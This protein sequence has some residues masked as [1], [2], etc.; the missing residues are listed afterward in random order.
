MSFLGAALELASL[1][2]HVFP[3][4]PNTKLP[5]IEDFPN[6]ASQDPAQIKKWW[7]DPVME[8]E[9][10]Y[11]VGISTTRFGEKE[12]LLVV[13]VDNK[14]D[15][16]G[17]QELKRLESEG[18]S[19]PETFEQ[20]TPTGGRH[21]VFRVISPVKQGVSVLGNGLDVRS[22]GGYIVGAGS[23]LDGKSY[24]KV[25][26]SIVEAPE[27]VVANC[28]RS[29]ER[30][31]QPHR[32]VKSVDR[33][34]AQN[35]A[36]HFLENEAP[37]SIKGQG[38]DQTA[39]TVACKVKDFGVEPETCLELMLDHWNER[40]PP[41]WS[42][43][44]LKEKVDHAYRYGVNPVGEASPEAHFSSIKEEIKVHPFDTL[45]AEYAYIGGN[46]GFILHETTDTD[47]KFLLEY[48]DIP[49]FHTNL[50]ATVMTYAG[51]TVPVTKLWLLSDKRRSFDGFCFIPGKKPPARFYNLWRGF[52]F[53][54]LDPGEKSSK[55][56][57]DALNAFLEHAE[58]NVCDGDPKLYQWLLGYFAHLIQKPW[59]KPLV[60]LVFRGQKGSG[61]NALIERIGD[62]LGHHF[63]VASDPRYLTGNFNSHLENKLLLVLDEAFWSGD[64]KAD[65]ILKNLV[66]GKKHLIEYKGKEP[67][68][69]DNR[70]RVAILGNED[71]LVPASEDERRY[72]VFDVGN[73]RREDRKFFKEMRQG[74]ESGGYRLLLRYLLDFDLS[75]IDV[76]QAPSTKALMDQKIRGLKPFARWW[77]DCLIEGRIAGSDFAGWPAYVEKERFRS[78]FRRYADEHKLGRY[79]PSNETFGRLLKKHTPSV[80]SNKQSEEGER[81]N[82]YQLPNLK[83][84]RREWNEFI[85][86][87]MT[88]EEEEI[89]S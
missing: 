49:K 62:L 52:A 67:Y 14:G 9:Q 64:P 34:R 76:D 71:W 74:M 8:I 18:R 46:K 2:F 29:I 60:A 13:D 56:H 81:V 65:A 26:G 66:T 39:Y 82:V 53:S 27:W 75:K 83:T 47:G 41:G 38:G 50:A 19:L 11:N 37:I 17:D 1:G 42:P 23:C 15:K 22:R 61:K 54:P 80:Y 70:T 72:A 59:E 45:N 84:A 7:L 57:V 58:K 5:L 12:A 21:L 3:L 86:H 63:L 69:V 16:N 89:F 48:I 36:I 35:R 31:P 10:P 24:T 85:G 33:I 77:F 32:N 43:E 6:F 73:G 20:H 44:R 68:T 88:W 87:E 4:I 51:K 28:G 55:K 25:D 30:N 78:A 40:C 79:F